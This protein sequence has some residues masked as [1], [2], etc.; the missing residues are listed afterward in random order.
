MYWRRRKCSKNESLKVQWFSKTDLLRSNTPWKQIQPLSRI[1]TLN[2]PT[3]RRISPVEKEKVYGG[4][5]LPQSQVLS[6][7]RED[8]SGDSEDGEEDDDKL[9]CVIG[10]SEGDCIWRGSWKSVGS[11]FHRKG[12]AY[13]KERLVIFKEDRVGGR[14]R[15]AIDEERVLWQGWTEIKLRRY[16]GWFVLKTLYVRERGLYLM[17]SFILSQCRDLRTGVMWEDFG[18]LVTARAREFWMFWNIFIWDCG[19]L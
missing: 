17:R 15:V 4:N 5:D 9:L 1:K 16:W 3:V 7:V 12:A 13:Q 11:S 8:A 2:G 18:V 10:E 6:S 19:R 14:A